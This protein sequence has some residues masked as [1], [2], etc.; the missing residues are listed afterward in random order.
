MKNIIM[1][2]LFLLLSACHNYSHYIDPVGYESRI[3][4]QKSQP[5]NQN[6]ID[7]SKKEWCKQKYSRAY[8]VVLNQT[9]NNNKYLSCV[10]EQVTPFQALSGRRTQAGKNCDACIRAWDKY[11]ACK[12]NQTVN[13][14]GCGYSPTCAR[15]RPGRCPI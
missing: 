6:N 3:A 15:T 14:Y 13:S 10:S 5:Q 1:I 2:V 4:Q 7:P 12:R 8:G 11:N 9:R